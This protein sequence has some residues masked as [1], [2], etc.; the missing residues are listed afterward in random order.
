MVCVDAHSSVVVGIRGGRA[1]SSAVHP[2]YPVPPP[3]PLPLPPFLVCTQAEAKEAT[4]TCLADVSGRAGG[5][6]DDS[7]PSKDDSQN[8][9]CTLWLIL[10]ISFSFTPLFL[11]T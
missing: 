7:C 11:V 8:T 3:P 5:R 6:A 4:S 10:H 1:Y 2:T 9:T